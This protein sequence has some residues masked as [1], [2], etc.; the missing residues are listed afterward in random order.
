MAPFPGNV[1]DQVSIAAWCW[2]QG[3][4]N[5]FDPYEVISLMADICSVDNIGKDTV[6]NTMHGFW[7]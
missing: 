4:K 2:L 1:Y 5:S 6:I 3:W 7:N